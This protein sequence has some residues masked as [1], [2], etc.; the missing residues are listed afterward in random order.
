MGKHLGESLFSLDDF[1]PYIRLWATAR[2]RGAFRRIAAALNM[3]T[4]LVSQV[5]NGKK[6]LTEEQA[7]Q[8]CE[9]MGLNHL[10]TDY[11]I[12]LVQYERAGTKLLKETFQRHIEEIR[13]AAK[14]IKSRV[15]ESKQLSLQDYA[16]FYS[17]WQ[18]ALIRLLTSIE[19]F[20]TKEAIASRLNL[21]L[22]RTQEVLDF[23]TSRGLCTENRG[24]YART[25]KNTHIEARSPLASRHHQNWRSKSLE[26]L[27]KLTPDDLAFTAPVSLAKKD[28]PRVRALLLDAISEISKIIEKSSA[29]EV[30]YLGVDWISA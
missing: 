12:K 10:E 23:L 11:F 5:I 25:E 21:S 13:S 4:T 28:I 14:E 7:T 16:I 20:Q 6:C 9:Y 27:E 22:S 30:V 1:R 26:L 29:E 8:M 24:R 2:G 19:Q 17:S 3:H 15:P 18:Y